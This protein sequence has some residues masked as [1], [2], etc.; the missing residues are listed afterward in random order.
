[1]IIYK[2]TNLINNKIYIGQDKNNNPKYLG[3]GDLLKKAIKK[4]GKENFKKEILCF[5]EN[6]E[7]LNEKERLYILKYDSRNLEF[8]YN[9]SVGGRN[10]TTLNRKMSDETKTKMSK[11]RLGIK[12]SDDHKKNIS[13]SLTG[14]IISEETKNKMSE[15]Q[16]K[17]KH[18]PLS[19]ETKTKMSKIR[20]GIKLS[21]ETKNKMSE[22]HKGEKNGF[23]G[24][25]HSD[26]FL[27]KK[28][29]PILEI[30]NTNEII[31]EWKSIKIASKTLNLH[32]SGIIN[33]LK[34]KN[35][36]TK[37]FK[38]IYKNE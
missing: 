29:K 26:E 31:R 38:F 27:I 9:I 34:G 1:M 12:F 32:E 37:G 35:K 11:I 17:I 6:Q 28:R 3:S 19:L 13:K 21:D 23:F 25:K 24:K 4:Y 10:G 2:T 16:K 22:S 7:E 18:N 20:L 30:S 5:C 15:S 8:G 33:V 14:K 36:T